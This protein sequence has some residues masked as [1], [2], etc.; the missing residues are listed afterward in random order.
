MRSEVKH[1]KGLQHRCVCVCVC[2]CVFVCLRVCAWACVRGV[3]GSQKVNWIA[4]GLT[5]NVWLER[6]PL[7]PG[8]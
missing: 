8:V 2:V 7:T 4:S 5:S 6:N 3:K 1:Y